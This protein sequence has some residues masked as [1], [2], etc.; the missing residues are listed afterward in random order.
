ML[1]LVQGGNEKLQLRRGSFFDGDTYLLLSKSKDLPPNP[2][3][4]FGVHVEKTDRGA[5]DIRDADDLP[6]L[7]GLEV[8]RP[9]VRAGMKQPREVTRIGIETGKIGTLL[10]VAKMTGQRQVVQFVSAVVLPGH[11]VLDVK[12]EIGIDALMNP[13]ILATMNGTRA[14]ELSRFRI[15]YGADASARDR[16]LSRM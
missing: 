14:D 7:R 11:D 9:T 5:A 12:R 1:L 15:H 2:R 10:G 16:A 4:N 3:A 13:A 8:I 6:I